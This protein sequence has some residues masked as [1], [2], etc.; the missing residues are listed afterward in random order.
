MA[1]QDESLSFSTPQEWVVGREGTGRGQ[2]AL[3]RRE[4]RTMKEKALN[5]T[6]TASAKRERND[7]LCMWGGGLPVALGGKPEKSANG[8]INPHVDDRCLVKKSHH[9]ALRGSTVERWASQL[10]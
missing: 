1:K 5:G 3:P 9:G 4:W 6:N 10:T 2:E 7:A 8:R